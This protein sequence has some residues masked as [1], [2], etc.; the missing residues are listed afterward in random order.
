MEEDLGQKPAQA[1][2]EWQAKES[3]ECDQGDQRHGREWCN[4]VERNDALR[5][6]AS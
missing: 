1:I 4:S 3:P 6:V 5:V 2:K